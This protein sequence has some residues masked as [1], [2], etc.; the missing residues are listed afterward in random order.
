MH[1]FPDMD[2]LICFRLLFFGVDSK[3][4]CE[5][6]TWLLSFCAEVPTSIFLQA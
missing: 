2:W 1:E 4:I 6:F 5:F 3:V